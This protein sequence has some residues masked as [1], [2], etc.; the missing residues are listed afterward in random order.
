MSAPRISGRPAA[1]ERCG[2]AFC[3]GVAEDQCWCQAP[4]L[5]ASTRRALAT[6]YRACLCPA[7]LGELAAPAERTGGGS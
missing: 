7:C 4:E 3:C 5:P 6:T 2:G 1:C